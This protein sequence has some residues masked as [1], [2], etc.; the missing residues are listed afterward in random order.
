V[1]LVNML[2][3]KLKYSILPSCFWC[4][5]I[6]NGDGCLGSSLPDHS[7]V[8]KC[9]ERVISLS[10]PDFIVTIQENSAFSN[11]EIC[12]LLRCY[13]AS[14]GNPLQTF[15]DKVWVPSSRVK[16]FSEVHWPLSRNVGK[17]LPLDA[18]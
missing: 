4:I 7:A 17:G 9:R 13:A 14:S 5:I 10:I 3:R 18:T 6:C 11:F 8:V 12:A 16:K 2:P 15:R 1:S